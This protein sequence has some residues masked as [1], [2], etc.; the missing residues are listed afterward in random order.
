MNVRSR[1]TNY[2]YFICHEARFAAGR[3]I[4]WNNLIG[5]KHF[6]FRTALHFIDT[7][8]FGRS[9]YTTDADFRDTRPPVS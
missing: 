3:V 8:R 1:N 5:S 4:T 9:N 7:S 2:R 6:I